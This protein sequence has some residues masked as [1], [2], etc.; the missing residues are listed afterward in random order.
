MNWCRKP[1][2]KP[3]CRYEFLH[4][5]TNASFRY[6]FRGMRRPEKPAFQRR[7]L[8]HR[9]YHI[10][11]CKVLTSKIDRESPVPG[12]TCPLLLSVSRVKP[13]TRG[14]GTGVSGAWLRVWCFYS[15][16]LSGQYWLLMG[17]NLQ[18]LT[19]GAFLA[20]VLDVILPMRLV[21]ISLN[22]LSTLQ[23]G[24]LIPASSP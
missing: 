6:P 12:S 8:L 24:M 20:A 5:E 13:N 7:I 9:F 17:Q 10:R 18:S 19:L 23:A 15:S 4:I 14:P 3:L 2:F 22:L 11:L 1:L 21:V 16:L